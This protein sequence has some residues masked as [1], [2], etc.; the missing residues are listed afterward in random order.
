MSAAAQTL[1]ASAAARA[2]AS[3]PVSAW[4]H[5]LRLLP[6]V[7]R[8]TG[9]VLIGIL[10]QAGMGV[11]GTVL[12]VVMGVVIDC[13]QGAAQPMAQLGRMGKLMLYVLPAYHPRTAHTI[14]AFCIA[15]LAVV[16]L[17]G[18]F[19]FWTRWIL[20]GLSRDVEYD[21]RNDLLDRLVKMEPEYYVRN[22]TG[23]LMS[24]C[25][26]DL[27]SV[28]MVLGP[29]IM[30]SA[31]TLATMVLALI[32]MFWLSPR[33]SIYVL[34]PVPVVAFVVFY[35]GRQIHGLYA[36]IQASLASLSSRAQEN[37]AG[38]RVIRAYA[39]EDAEIKGFDEPN[40]EYID[41]NLRLIYFWSLFMPAL[42]TLIGFTFLLVLWQGGRLVMLHRISLGELIVF[43]NFMLQL[44]FP[45][46][47][48]GF[49]TNIWQRG[50][51]SMGRL[52]YILDAKPGIDDRAARV[53]PGQEIHGEIELRHLNF[54]YPTMSPSGDR[55][56]S[57]ATAASSNGDGEDSRSD[58]ALED[59]TLEVPA[60]ST[61]A[62]VG[63]TGS[64]KSTMAALLA[65]LWEAPEGTL[66]LDRRP[67]REWPLAELRRAV[68]FV[69]QDAFLFSKTI[70][71][72][73]AFGVEDASPERIRAAADIAGIAAE[74]DDFPQ[75]YETLLG[76]RGITVSGGQ[77]QRIALARAVIR[78]P[79]VLVLDDSLSSV[80]TDTE[81]RILRRLREFM[82]GRTTILISHRCSTVRHADQIAVLRAGR[83]VE[84][85]TH[86]E[87][88]ER[89]GYYADLYQKQL[90]E[91]ELERA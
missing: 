61:L 32:L 80:D 35:F 89:N 43:Y 65:R 39:Q 55:A 29:G 21:L 20:I 12:P 79:K 85:G 87:L 75:G 76:E 50:A 16:A 86:E 44:V 67:V 81:D 53:E 24:R 6:Y 47:A 33:L 31:N 64:G 7:R 10:M 60:G 28:R 45:M 71:E 48:L 58:A 62:V 18:V 40:R 1:P 73:I 51:A 13:V 3:K 9:M 22:R 56:A 14:I 11:A 77:K 68:G 38:V 15:M 83:V 8:H 4:R 59:V 66:F 25:T 82:H 36:Q 19:S 34:L 52:N 41:R 49:V 42:Q 91:E 27:N 69:P 2:A 90:L 57:A 5:T 46:I 84:L 37:L 63:P 30:Y 70:G 88:L 23:E 78:D 17:K 54:R 74:I 26:N 72:N